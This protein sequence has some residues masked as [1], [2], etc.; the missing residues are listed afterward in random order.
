MAG[1]SKFANIKHKKEKQDA[2]RGK[3]F[4][5]LGRELAVAVKMGGA[6]P[7]GNARLKEAI[8]K[9]K[10]ANMP[11]DTIERSIKKAAGELDAVNYEAITYEGY[12]PGGI[13]VLVDALTD[14]RNRTVANVRHAFTKN[15]GN[16]GTS[17][18][19]AYQFDQIGQIIIE[20]APNIDEDELTLLALESGAA[21]I[22]ASDEG[23]EITCAPADF[24]ALNTALENAAIPILS[25]EILMQPKLYAQLTTPDDIKNINRLLDM[26]EDDDD[27]QNT[28]HNWENM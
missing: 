24:H 10:A 4:T 19:V 22:I 12:G 20:A 1:H 26:L 21:D 13:A 17:G 8:A 15:G 9:A 11:G 25:A 7:A 16:L 3:I 18:S 23:Y 28:Y 5:K 14:N 6:D 2:K 27:V